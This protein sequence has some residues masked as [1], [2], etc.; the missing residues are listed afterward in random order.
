MY[1]IQGLWIAAPH[2]VGALFVVISN[3]G[4]AVMDGR[5]RDNGGYGP[6]PAL[7][8]LDSAP[9]SSASSGDSP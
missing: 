7:N 5:A 4:Y 2:R 1:S 8:G 6:W 3:G 9:S